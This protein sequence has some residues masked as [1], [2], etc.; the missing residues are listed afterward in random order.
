MLTLPE[1]HRLSNEELDSAIDRYARLHEGEPWVAGLWEERSR[2][3]SAG[4]APLSIKLT[5]AQADWLDDWVFFQDGPGDSLEL[6][7][8][9]T[10]LR[11]PREA[12][13]ELVGI[14]EDFDPEVDEGSTIGES[15]FREVTDSM[16][17][18]GI[19]AKERLK[20]SLLKKLY[21]ALGLLEESRIAAR[22]ARA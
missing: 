5:P 8:G 1:I 9:R 18:F 3:I 6:E 11:G 21:K 14:V 2:R 17:A 13:E 22:K 16:V 7:V 10:Y 19:R 20:Y 15:S 4:G 12:F